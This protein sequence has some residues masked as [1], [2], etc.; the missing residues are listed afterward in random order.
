MRL[1]QDVDKLTKQAVELVK[2]CQISF[3]QR[4]SAYRQYGQ[5][6]ETGRNAGSLSIA[7]LLYGHI[8]RLASH[9]FSPELLRFKCDFEEHYDPIWLERGDVAARK[10]SRE[11]ERRNVDMLF[12][13]GVNVALKYGAC[14]LKQ[15]GGV[16]DEDHPIWRGAQL[17]PPW[18]VGVYNEGVN[19]LEDQEA[20]LQVSYLNRHEVWRRVRGLPDAEKLFKSILGSAQSESGVGAPTSF[21]HQVLSTAVLNTS[22]R[23]MT[24]PQPGG[25]VQLTNDPNFATLGPQVAAQLYPLNEL[26]VRDDARGG[27]DWTTIQ[28]FDP[29]VLVAPR[30]KHCNLFAPHVFPYSIIQ[31]N[32]ELGYQFG[33]SEIVDLMMLQDWLTTH[34][35]DI[36][37]LTGLQR[38]KI[39]GFEGWEGLTDETYAQATRVSGTIATPTG[40]TI[41]DLTPQLPANLIEI[42][43]EIIGLMDRASGFSPIMSGQGESG[44]RAG[45]HADTLMKTGSPRLRD[46][47]LLLE[48][49]CS[50]AAD[51]T[52]AFFEAK[53]AHA[54]RTTPGVESTEF[55]LKQLMED[56][57][58]SVDAHSSSPIYH[59]DQANLIAFGVKAGFIDGESAIE[60][61]PYNHKDILIARFKAKQEYERKLVEKY[62]PEILM[63]HKSHHKAA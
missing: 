34:L 44:V 9:L 50:A 41:K 15:L 21:M 7:N 31:P 26:W 3:G 20:F 60:M 56:R 25:I 29:D 62:G 8:D 32:W 35:D 36:K 57:R 46:R 55:L 17:I 53:D 61:L 6:C 48:R 19:G 45:V 13:H 54:Y 43:R 14:Y 10:I 4:Q 49:Q 37:A 58:I 22:L 47:S 33:R 51:T 40:S 1:A 18:A 30:L 27:E 16:D 2:D 39:L 63:G 23:N 52:L 12:G 42:A 24:Q 28:L 38:D 59:D 11:W 5:W